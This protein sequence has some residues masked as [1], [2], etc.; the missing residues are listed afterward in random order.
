MCFLRA[1]LYIQG[2]ELIADIVDI[3]ETGMCLA[4]KIEDIS[5]IKI[6]EKMSAWVQF[7]DT[8]VIHRVPEDYIER[9]PVRIIY[10][11]EQKDL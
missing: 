6:N 5:E 2:N 8:V 4:V 10:S 11:L 1:T 3:S 7:L 9:V